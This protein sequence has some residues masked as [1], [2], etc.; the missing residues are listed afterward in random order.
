MKLSKNFT[1]KEMQCSCGCDTP[2][3]VLKAAVNHVEYLEKIREAVGKPLHINSWYRCP[4]YNQSI[5]G[6][7]R[8]KHLEGIATDISLKNL[9]VDAEGLKEIIVGLQ[10]SGDIKQD[11]GIGLYNTFLHFDSRI[12]KGRWD[13]RN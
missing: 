10:L 6:V 5:G 9:D 1:Y 2:T 13:N 12:G 4:T 11:C 3:N 8:S 7:S